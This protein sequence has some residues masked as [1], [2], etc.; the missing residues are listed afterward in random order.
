VVAARKVDVTVDP[1]TMEATIPP[2]IEKED[3]ALPV[4]RAR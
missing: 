3:E 4:K 2:Y 1:E